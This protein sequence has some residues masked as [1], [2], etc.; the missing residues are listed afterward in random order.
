V[1]LFHLPFVRET[2]AGAQ[3]V[4]ADRMLAL[5]PVRRG[6]LRYRVQ[7]RDWGPRIERLRTLVNGAPARFRPRP[8]RTIDRRARTEQAL[9]RALILERSGLKRFD[10]DA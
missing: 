6:R 9:R 2:G 1:E 3:I 7:F 8:R 5:H 10:P 4:R